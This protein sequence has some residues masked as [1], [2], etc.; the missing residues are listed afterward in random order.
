MTLPDDIAELEKQLEPAARAVFALLRKTNEELTQ[1]NKELTASNKELAVQVAK[2][3][4][5]VAKFQKDAV[6]QKGR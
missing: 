4:S 5:R 6:R 1:S 2:L 3:N